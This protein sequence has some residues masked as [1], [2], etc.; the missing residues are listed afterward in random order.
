MMHDLVEKMFCD[1]MEAEGFNA[2]YESE[3]RWE[4]WE[5]YMVEAGLDTEAVGNFFSEM[6]WDL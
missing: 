1:L 5:A 6:A 3:E 4:A 2:W